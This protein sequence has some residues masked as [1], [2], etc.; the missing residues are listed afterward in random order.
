MEIT[1]GYSGVTV[2]TFLPLTGVRT[3]IGILFAGFTS[4]IASNTTLIT[5]EFFSKTKLTN[6][7]L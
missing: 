1:L 6:T 5:N 7:N 2:G 3:C 4:F